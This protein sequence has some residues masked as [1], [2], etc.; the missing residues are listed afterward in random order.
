VFSWFEVFP[1]LHMRE[2]GVAPLKAENLHIAV[3]VG[4]LFETR[5]LTYDQLC[6]ILY[7]QNALRVSPEKE[8]PEASASL[9]SL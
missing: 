3:A 8:E 7:E 4:G 9:A 6:N 5:V 1:Y 2:A